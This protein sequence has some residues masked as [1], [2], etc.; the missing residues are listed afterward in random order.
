MRAAVLVR[1][2]V[3]RRAVSPA[4]PVRHSSGDIAY[5]G[6]TGTTN[7]GFLSV[8]KKDY[9]K[10]YQSLLGAFSGLERKYIAA[11]DYRRYGLHFEDLLIETKDVA[12]ALKRVPRD[13][14]S[15]RDDR[16]KRAFILQVGG[17]ELPRTEWTREEDDLPYLAPYLASVVQERR[18]RE[19]F[20]PK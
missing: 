14:L 13:V 10:W 19:A 20:N 2:S 17:N 1:A 3:R 5:P 12:L 18:D 16:I 15:D 11:M 7:F 8:N 9:P 6:I 4:V